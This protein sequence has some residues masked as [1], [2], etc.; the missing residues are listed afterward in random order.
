MMRQVVSLIV[1]FTISFSCRFSEV[2]VDSDY[3]YTGKFHRYKTFSFVKNQTFRGADED[4]EL[5]EQ[6][7]G[8]ILQSW[9]Y[10]QKENRPDFLISYDFF[11][12]DVTLLGYHQPD[13]HY[14]VKSRF[15]SELIEQAADTLSQEEEVRRRDERYNEANMKLNQGTIY[16]TFLDR[17]RDA[18][19]WQGYASGVFSGDIQ[20]NERKLRAAIIRILDQF[21]LI[22]VST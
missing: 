15:G 14:W 10:K 20:N 1:L 19:V 7:I 22:S 11:Y 5:I 21:R 13:F 9:G 12:D 3:S 2:E 17:K 16:V 18:S 8:R 6:N 4:K